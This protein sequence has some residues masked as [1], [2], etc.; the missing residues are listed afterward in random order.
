M[1]ALWPSA[2]AQSAVKVSAQ[3]RRVDST[4][5]KTNLPP[6]SIHS[7]FFHSTLLC[8]GRYDSKENLFLLRQLDNMDIGILRF[9]QPR[10]LI[11]TWPVFISNETETCS[12]T[13]LR[14]KS[15]FSLSLPRCL[16]GLTG[17]HYLES[18]DLSGPG[19]LI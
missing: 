2:G 5:N 18:I 13:I 16:L 12:R 19:E 3:R 1:H 6:S 14:F 8:R 4:R 9:D 17:V 11:E 7:P 10:C 15:H